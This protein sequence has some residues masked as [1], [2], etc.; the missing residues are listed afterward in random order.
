MLVEEISPWAFP[1]RR[2]RLVHGP[3]EAVRAL[4]LMADGNL[5]EGTKGADIPV[6]TV[7]EDAAFGG[8]FPR[9]LGRGGSRWHGR[10]LFSVAP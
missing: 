3:L 2:L 1:V 7:A 8:F 10:S 9:R 5:G 6:P 4:H